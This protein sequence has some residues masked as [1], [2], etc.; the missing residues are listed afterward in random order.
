MNAMAARVTQFCRTHHVEILYAFGSRAKQA[1]SALSGPPAGHANPDSVSTLSFFMRRTRFLPPTSSEAS[2]SMPWM[3]TRRT[4]TS[5]T[6]CAAPG[7]ARLL[8]GSDLRTLRDHESREALA[9]SGVL[10]SPQAALFK[11]LAGY[12][13]RLVHIYHEV[14]QDELYQ[15]C[16][17]RLGDVV[18]AKDALRVWFDSHPDLVDD[19]L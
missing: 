7:T 6:S 8:S 5:F 13:N 3:N 9:E 14:S 11:I 16:S 1:L 10:T 17:T 19:R 12:R 15:I 2:V 18:A 4:N